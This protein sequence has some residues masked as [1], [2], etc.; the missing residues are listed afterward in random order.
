MLPPEELSALRVP[1]LIWAILQRRRLRGCV[2]I[3]NVSIR[4]DFCKIS[5]TIKDN[6]FVWYFFTAAAHKSVAFMPDIAENASGMYLLLDYVITV[7]NYFSKNSLLLHC[8][9]N[10]WSRNADRSSPAAG[11]NPISTR[12]KL[13][14]VMSSREAQER[15]WC[16]KDPIE[17]QSAQIAVL[18]WSLQRLRIARQ[19]NA[20]SSTAASPDRL[21]SNL[22]VFWDDAPQLVA[23]VLQLHVARF[24]NAHMPSIERESSSSFSPP[25][26]KRAL[27]AALSPADL[28]PILPQPFSELRTPLITRHE[29]QTTALFYSSGSV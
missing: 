10:L 19:Q 4:L 16:L 28:I 11:I 26:A 9:E 3:Q 17:R 7:K 24:V 8:K 6:F 25:A 18:E 20:A 5:K 2:P 1:A 22:I 27:T 21:A 15:G 23:R 29:S 14:F 13:R 12:N